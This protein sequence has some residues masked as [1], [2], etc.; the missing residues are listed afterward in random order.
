M[1]C[2]AISRGD[3][4]W[5][6]ETLRRALRAALVLSVSGGVLLG[7]VARPVIQAWAGFTPPTLLVVAASIW[8]VVMTTAAVL[9][10]FLNGARVVRAQIALALLMMTSNLGLSI[11]FTHWVGVSGVIWGSIV[12]QSIVVA[13]VSIALVP[14]VLRRLEGREPQVSPI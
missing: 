12:A 1:R 14:R 6:R 4:Q 9:A 5:V 10:A 7:L 2:E 13:I 8:I 11:A 3:A